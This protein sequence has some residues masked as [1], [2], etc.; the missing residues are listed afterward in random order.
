MR[1]WIRA[2]IQRR[3]EKETWAPTYTTKAA[4]R[5]QIQVTNAEH[6]ATRAARGKVATTRA[7]GGD[8]LPY[9]GWEM[10]NYVQLAPPHL[11]VE[12]VPAWVDPQTGRRYDAD[13]TIGV[14][15]WPR[16]ER[17]YDPVDIPYESW[18]GGGGG[19]GG[20][21]PRGDPPQGFRSW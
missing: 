3:S 12:Q 14:D 16:L 18:P 8:L 5:G 10:A 15:S 17:R 11:R 4:G 2:Y 20:P 6:E 21:G 7:K 19:G 13:A 1:N 9:H